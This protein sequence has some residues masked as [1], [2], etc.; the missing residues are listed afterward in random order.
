MPEL[1]EIKYSQ[2]DCIAA[3]P[4]RRRLA[5][6]YRRSYAG[7]GKDKTVASLLGHLPYMA[8]PTTSEGEAQPIPFLY[9]ADWPGVCAWIKSGQLTAEDARDASQAY[10]DAERVPPHVISLTCGGAETAAILLD[11][12]LGGIFWPE[13][14]GG[15]V[16]DPCREEVLDDAYDYVPK[17]E[18]DWRAGGGRWAIAD[19][20]E[21]LK[22]EFRKL[23]F[24]PFYSRLVREVYSVDLKEF[25]PML[26][27]IYRKHG[28]P[29]ME[30]YNKQKCLSEVRAEL[31]DKFP[32]Y[33][34]W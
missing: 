23:S 22:Y 26:Q 2:Q 8:P 30:I 12:K 15:V 32:G 24:V 20:F 14:T 3:I 16:W 6:N 21:V 34:Y 27:E 31:E 13:C 10:M 18:A 9:F 28:W 19:F 33:I 4:T 5:I 1:S 7:V 11:T 29:N 17:N 25:I